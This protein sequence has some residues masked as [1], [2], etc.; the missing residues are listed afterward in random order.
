MRNEIDETKSRLTHMNELE[1]KC[2]HQESRC[3]FLEARCDSLEETIQLPMKNQELPDD[4]A[5]PFPPNDATAAATARPESKQKKVVAASAREQK[6]SFQVL[7]VTPNTFQWENQSAKPSAAADA[8]PNENGKEN[9][10]PNSKSSAFLSKQEDSMSHCGGKDNYPE[11]LKSTADSANYDGP[12]GTVDAE[13]PKQQD[14]ANVSES[15]HER[16]TTAS[17]QEDNDENHKNDLW[18]RE[19]MSAKE[20]MNKSKRRTLFV[21]NLGVNHFKPFPYSSTSSSPESMKKVNV[22]ADNAN[23]SANASK[24][25]HVHEKSMGANKTNKSKKSRRDAE[26]RAKALSRLQRKCSGYEADF[27]REFTRGTLFVDKLGVSHFRPGQ[28]DGQ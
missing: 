3:Q 5:A 13:R 23:D 20:E 7:K 25:E 21:D 11:S 6:S 14:S 27:K 19:A 12:N 4:D 24:S 8:Y 9:R 16:S 18:L 26:N 15:E 10:L 1:R 17:E 22:D 28:M 2:K